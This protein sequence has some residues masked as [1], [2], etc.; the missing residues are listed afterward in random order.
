MLTNLPTTRRLLHLSPKRRS[1]EVSNGQHA[2][3]PRGFQRDH[4]SEQSR[5]LPSMSMFLS[6]KNSNTP[7]PL[8]N[9]FQARSFEVLEGGFG[10]VMIKALTIILVVIVRCP[11]GEEHQVADRKLFPVFMPLE[12]RCP[13]P[14]V[15]PPPLGQVW[16]DIWAGFQQVR[17]N[18]VSQL[19]S[20]MAF[21]ARCPVLSCPSPPPMDNTEMVISQLQDRV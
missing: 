21:Q 12:R 5:S 18:T 6:L 11:F 15:P 3:K 2:S 4:G 10:I 7:E 8:S 17:L 13:T 9:T 20:A 1:D 16:M 19:Q 14:A